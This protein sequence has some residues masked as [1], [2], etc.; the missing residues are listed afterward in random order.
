MNTGLLLSLAGLALLDS[1]SM[2]TLFIPIWLM[3]SPARVGMGRILVYLASIAVFYFGVGL[4][5]VL[6]A[7]AVFSAAGDALESRTALWIQL[8]I[9]VGLFLLS[10]RFAPKKGEA[11]GRDAS[12][13]WRERSETRSASVL[14]IVGLALLAAL[15]EVATMLP[16]LGAIGMLTTSGLDGAAVVALLAGYCVIMILPALVLLV[17]RTMARDRMQPP[18]DRLNAWFSKRADG[19]LGWVLAIVG[20]LVARDAV[21]RLWYPEMF[22]S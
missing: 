9:G 1:A 21:A 2:G 7:D 18:L 12:S 20:F 17:A 15:V 16:Y 14:W 4:L 10:F 5:V 13:R 11:G 22:G 19:A 3:L 6:G 8:V